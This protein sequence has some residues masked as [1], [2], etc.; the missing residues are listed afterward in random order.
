MLEANNIIVKSCDKSSASRKISR[1]KSPLETF[2]DKIPDLS[3]NKQ[4]PDFVLDKPLF[5]ILLEVDEN[6]HKNR[7][8]EC[9]Q[10]RMIQLHNDFGGTPVVFIRYNP[11]NYVDNNGKRMKPNNKK[12]EKKLLEILNGLNNR[13]EWNIPLSSYYLYYDGYDNIDELIELNYL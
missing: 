6:Q 11:D 8:F 5:T 13:K 1:K 3:C 9:E 4:R 10:S 12:R 7:T 2:Y